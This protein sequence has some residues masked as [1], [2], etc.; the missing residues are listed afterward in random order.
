MAQNVANVVFMAIC[1][2]A[3]TSARAKCSMRRKAKP[4]QFTPVLSK[5]RNCVTVASVKKSHV[6]YGVQQK[7]LDYQMKNLRKI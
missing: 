1:A 4:A 2:R 6:K 3:A 5:L 7:T